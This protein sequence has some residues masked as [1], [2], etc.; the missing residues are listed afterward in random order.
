MIILFFLVHLG[1]ITDFPADG[2]PKYEFASEGHMTREDIERHLE[3]RRVSSELEF[4]TTTT[5]P[6][7]LFSQ[8]PEQESDLEGSEVCDFTQFEE[9]NPVPDS[10]M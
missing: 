4:N 6:A 5:V 7:E 9:N 2:M 10:T 8:D 1:R 3:A